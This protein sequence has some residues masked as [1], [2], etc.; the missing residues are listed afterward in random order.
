MLVNM[1][2]TYTHDVGWEMNWMKFDFFI[3]SDSSQW[4]QGHSLERL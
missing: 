1:E 3:H 4:G 2:D